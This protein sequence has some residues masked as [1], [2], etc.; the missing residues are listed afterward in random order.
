MDLNV[1]CVSTQFTGTDHG[2]MASGDEEFT[3]QET[4]GFDVPIVIQE[5]GRKSNQFNNFQV[6]NKTNSYFYHERSAVMQTN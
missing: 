4:S 2:G 6:Q 1:A 5:N 3:R